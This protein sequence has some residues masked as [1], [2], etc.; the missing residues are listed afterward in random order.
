MNRPYSYLATIAGI[1]AVMLVLFA[2]P[3]YSGGPR[4]VKAGP[5]A[6]SLEIVDAPMLRFPGGHNR[7]R[8]ADFLAD[9]N[10][11]SHWSGGRLYLINSWEQPWRSSGPDLFHLKSDGMGQFTD[12]KLNALW[13]WIEST[14][15]DP[16]GTLYGWYHQEI[17]NVCPDREGAAAPGYP[18]I[19]K[20]GALRSPDD[21]MTWQDLGWVLASP[22]GDKKCFS[23]NAWYAG[24]AGDFIAYADKDQKFF[25]FYFAN[26][27]SKVYEQ[28]ICVARLPFS[29]RANPVG[30]VQ[31]WYQGQWSEPGIG[32]H[33]TPVFPASID[34]YRKDGQTYW[35]PVIHW[36]TF[37]N[38]YVMVLNRIQDTRWATEG[39]YISFSID[40][41][42][43]NSWSKPVKI[44][45]REE[46][47]QADPAKKGNGWYV[48]I[49]GIRPGET[50]KVAS[51][52]ARLFV[53]GLSRWEIR[54]RK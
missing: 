15:K 43:P 52:T 3:S 8:D 16:K 31:R 6:P 21:G 5:N 13:F 24:G 48:L 49:V 35:G 4:A 37:L 41:S 22:P 53:D 2:G 44:M 45:D 19:V 30:K 20:I 54:F 17:P 18:V 34:M 23:G 36:N 47:I 29:D 14:W 42:D 11:P 39:I 33:S 40:V 7:N 50:D 51:Q 10:S 26:Y 9:S 1:A 12:P 46:A 25:Y 27:S 28:G 32:G 38:K